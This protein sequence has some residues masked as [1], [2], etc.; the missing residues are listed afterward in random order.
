NSFTLASI[1]ARL[2]S[3]IGTHFATSQFEPSLRIGKDEMRPASTSYSP[4]AQTATLCQSPSGV[5]VTSERTVSTTAFAAE[6]ADERARAAI[7]RGFHRGASS[8]TSDPAARLW[9]CSSR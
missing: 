9:R 5:G 6:A 3:L 8:R 1:L 7:S 2:K 4:F